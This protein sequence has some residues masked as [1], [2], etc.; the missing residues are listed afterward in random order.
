MSK[1][2]LLFLITL[3]FS[4]LLPQSIFG[5][6]I[7]TL[8]IT[9]EYTNTIEV[10]HIT[11]TLSNT[12]GIT[13]NKLLLHISSQKETTGLDFNVVVSGSDFTGSFYMSTSDSDPS[14]DPYNRPIIKIFKYDIITVSDT[15]SQGKSD[16]LTF[17][18][19][20]P[21]I[22]SI[23]TITETDGKKQDYFYSKTISVNVTPSTD[24]NTYIDNQI[25]YVVPVGSEENYLTT[26]TKKIIDTNVSTSI[27]INP[28]DLEIPD[29]NYYIL[30]DANDIA[31]NLVLS[32]SVLN[33]K[34]LVYFDNSAPKFEETNLGPVEDDSIIY[35]NKSS[36]FDLNIPVSDISGINDSS[37]NTSY[38]IIL[39]DGGPVIGNYDDLTKTFYITFTPISG[40]TWQTDD[41]FVITLDVMDNVDN[42]LELDFNIV[43]DKTAPEIPDIKTLSIDVDK[44]VTI[45]WDAVTD[46]LSG[47][48]EYKVYRS[49]SSFTPVTTQT[50]ICTVSESD[51][52]SCKDTTSKPSESRLYY[53]VSAI[54]FA[55]N[56][57]D[58]NSQFIHTG[59]S[60]SIEVADG[61]KFT[62]SAT[63]QMDLEFSDDVNLFAFS[64]NGSSFTNFIDID[65]D[66]VFNIINGT[67]CNNKQEEKTIYL[68]VK[69]EDDPYYTTIC[70][71]EIIY[72]AT[73]PTIPSNFTATAQTNGS[74]KL[75]WSSSDDNLSDDI[76]YRIY[77]SKQTAVTKNDPYLETDNLQTIFNPN[78]QA[79]FY[80]KISAID[81]AGNESNL[82]EEKSA[83]A[84]RYGPTFTLSIVPSNDING[85]LYV[86]K[87]LKN[88][89]FLSDQD[90]GA[91]PIVTLKIGNTSRILST[92]R[93]GKTISTTFDFTNSAES[94][95]KISGKN[96]QN[97]SAENIFN[98]IVDSNLPLFDIN[99]V[100][101]D[102]KINLDANNFS[103]DLFRVQYI[104][105]DNE[106]IC[107]VEK[108]QSENFSCEFD[109]LSYS[110]GDYVLF[111]YGYDRALNV[112][113]K[114]IPFVINNVDEE[115]ESATF[116]KEKLTNDI[117][118][119]EERI[120]ILDDLLIELPKDIDS[121]LQNLKEQ[122]EVADLLFDQNKFVEAD[123]K[124][125]EILDQY[126]TLIN[127]LPEETQLKNTPISINYDLN[128]FNL[129]SKYVTDF[130]ILE[131]TNKLYESGAISIDRN[132][133]VQQ[134][135]LNKY[136]AVILSIENN[137][138]SAK[139]ITII[140]E[141]PK[142]FAADA[143]N[144]IFSKPVTILLRDPII[145]YSYTIPAKSNLTLSYKNKNVITDVDV[146]TKY[147]TIFFTDPVILSGEVIAEN[148]KITKP[149]NTKMIIYLVIAMFVLLV[150]LIIVGI[151]FK[152]K[153]EKNI[154]NMIKPE[155]GS[156][157]NDYL[158][159]SENTPKKSE[160]T[161]ETNSKKND[162]T[163]EEKFQQDYDYI[164]NAI[165]KR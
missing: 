1:K 72:D 75:A 70:S 69:S 39:P 89:T 7:S 97:E 95:L 44:N 54:D 40:S 140:E 161:K 129:V 63:P 53:G 136:F 86:G 10:Q 35:V 50:L 125:N 62:N 156:M 108:N 27:S 34:K 37:V 83:Q 26:Y 29:G 65:D 18:N 87:G 41:L 94:Q 96:T 21:I 77:Y 80:F 58:V 81:D 142:S 13:D 111:V 56:K 25:V 164:L 36:A 47:V 110:D 98:F 66:Y 101:E 124:Y 145:S 76:N 117:I 46:D 147:N 153:R 38:D 15:D 16:T 160:D 157:M 68:K 159:R 17:D 99:L 64:C 48:K 30:L 127:K 6:T 12:D 67:G 109:T 33:T 107:I 59:P 162:K 103:E 146:A 19:M 88:I 82:S 114:E 42:L 11:G 130:N 158:G 116:L 93:A 43:I 2:Y 84:R 133:I 23:N 20:A 91:E 24:S 165:K 134:I 120:L 143:S 155:T 126:T 14:Y 79:I 92:V 45:T 119:F 112:T 31:G 90:L 60:C 151:A 122:K 148:I 57:S 121:Q 115:K 61:D 22:G 105:N 52:K 128:K 100:R 131:D 8:D 137:S 85:V 118:A 73:A 132:F 3:I 5:Y 152:S 139:T 74:I 138:D 141:I 150:L 28:I 51:T 71:D 104:L 9:N 55:G 154:K 106:E 163:T 102:T 4:I 113:K 123:G 78:E 149:L 49:D 135:G 144:L 32:T